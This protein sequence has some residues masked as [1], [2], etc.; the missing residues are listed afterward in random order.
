MVNPDKVTVSTFE[1]LTVEVNLLQK[2]AK[3]LQRYLANTLHI[4]R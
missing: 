1:F 2:L 4:E 3:R